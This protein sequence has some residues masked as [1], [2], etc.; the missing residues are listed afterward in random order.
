MAEHRPPRPDEIHLD[1]RT[2]RGLAH[3]L[4]VRLL[5]MLRTDG[6]ATATRLAERLGLS[7]AAT[8]YHLRQLALYGF[9]TDDPE[10]GQPRERWW[11]AAHRGTTMDLGEALDDPEA[12][13]AGEVYLR[14]V[15]QASAARVMDHL[16]EVATLPP[17]W[18]GAGT[19]S[20]MLLRL[21]PQEA[22]EVATRMWD[23]VEQYRRADDEDAVVPDGA[24]RVNV[25][26]Q[27][28]PHPGDPS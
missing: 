24:R 18:R 23:L 1:A 7:S 11:K 15:A 13:A 8:S 4:R 10:R 3:P 19:L 12:L 14:S 25:Q 27:V 28:F 21:T 6:P 22:D 26:L 16:D 2:L 5:G 20:D 17:A 9:I